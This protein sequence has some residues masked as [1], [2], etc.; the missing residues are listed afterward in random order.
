MSR[1]S[2]AQISRKCESSQVIGLYA[3]CLSHLLRGGVDRRLV[4][5]GADGDVSL[6]DAG[7]RGLRG[8]IVVQPPLPAAHGV[9][10]TEIAAA[11]A[12]G[13][14]VSMAMMVV[15]VVMVPVVSPDAGALRPVSRRVM[16]A[17]GAP[18]R[19]RS[20]LDEGRVSGKL[21]GCPAGINAAGHLDVHVG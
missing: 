7:G 16:L 21:G 15:V 8:L 20:R 3:F 6:P 14:F 13:G 1:G 18:R 4:V 5:V 17:R 19:P 10:A 12:V 9:P 11:A 2:S